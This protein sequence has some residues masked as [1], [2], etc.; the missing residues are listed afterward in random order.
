MSL[1]KPEK[2]VRMGRLLS[3]TVAAATVLA[4]VMT[5]AQTRPS[6]AGTWMLDTA[7]S[8]QAPLADVQGRARGAGRNP[9]GTG[10]ARGDGQ[11]RA[12]GDGQ[13][14]ARG[15]GQGR[16]R[17]DGQGRGR[18][19][20]GRGIPGMPATFDQS[21]V[22]GQTGNDITIAGTTYKLDGTT[23]TLSDSAAAVTANAKWEGNKLVLEATTTADG[24]TITT[25]EVR[26]LSDDGKEMTVEST[27]T[28]PRGDVV[29]TKQ[30]FTKAG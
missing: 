16:G 13:G 30:I 4:P 11:G 19:A 23:S 1:S 24:R 22:I 6:F 12:R 27:A 25:K 14:R 5:A 3:F 15:D 17:G 29:T 9:D 20:R 8:Q 2:E 26:T 10:R 7:R 21:V 28:T 18:G